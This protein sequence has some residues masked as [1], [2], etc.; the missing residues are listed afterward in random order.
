MNRRE[1]IALAGGIPRI[2]QPRNYLARKIQH[3]YF[4]RFFAK[5]KWRNSVKAIYSELTIDVLLRRKIYSIEHIVPKSYLRAYL[6][7]THQSALLIHSAIFNPYNYAPSHRKVNA[8][9]SSLPYDMEDEQIAT[10]V[11]VK[12]MV[13]N[14]VGTDS[15][16]EW[17][18]PK[19][20]RGSVA[21]AVLY[22]SLMYGIDRI[23]S[24]PIEK[25]VPWALEQPPAL[26]ELEFNRWI[27]KK[28]MISNPFIERCGG[29]SPISL[30]HDKE[31]IEE[32]RHY[33][34]KRNST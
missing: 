30:C 28:Y 27:R 5:P 29:V 14:G 8:C 33:Y 31:L 1:F 3:K 2:P 23:G 24:D 32:L 25:F 20:S 12:K 16:G 13:A 6:A 34:K 9:R 4:W 11:R 19:R 17:V 15:E 18:V 10:T 7:N 21:R 22:M 26:W